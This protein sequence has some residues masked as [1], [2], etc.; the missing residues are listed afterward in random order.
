M[1]PKPLDINSLAERNNGG[2]VLPLTAPPASK[3]KFDLSELDSNRITHKTHFPEPIPTLSVNG[4]AFAVEREL[5]IITG[6]PKAGKSAVL[7]VMI[8]AP[9]VNGKD[10][11]TLSITA[12]SVKGRNVIY[13]DTEMSKG[14]TQKLHNQVLRIM[15][16]DT[17]PPN[18]RIWNWKKYTP[19][20]R[21]EALKATFELIPDIHLLFLDGIADFMLSVND[22]LKA[23]ELLEWLT[24]IA[25]EKNCS[26]VT[27]IHENF[28]NGQ[29]RGHIGSGLGRKC[30]GTISIK[31]DRAKDITSIECKTLRH[32]S[33][34]QP[35]YCQWSIDHKRL[36]LVDEMVSKAIANESRKTPEEKKA[37]K[38]DAHRNF[39]SD[40]LKRCFTTN[41]QLSR[42]DLIAALVVR[43]DQ[44]KEVTDRTATRAITDCLNLNL[45]TVDDSKTYHLVS[46]T[47]F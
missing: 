25:E 37:E 2:A 34:F 45:L 4:S 21:I 27:V 30:A 35:V 31:K 6:L 19:N 16:S 1:Q 17:T 11:D 39:L 29:A 38:E 7:S 20:E 41:R 13:I 28:G 8:A 44:E 12:P 43:Y 3:R 24:I 9:F 36:M 47:P 26:I 15:D 40:V 23:N 32:A 42:K 5:S 22:E 46:N 10:V 33:D 14:S 18:L